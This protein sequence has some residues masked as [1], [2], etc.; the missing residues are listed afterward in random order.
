MFSRSHL[1]KMVKRNKPV[2]HC[3][4]VAVRRGARVLDLKHFNT[5]ARFTRFSSLILYHLQH[6][7]KKNLS[8]TDTIWLA[9][10]FVK[11]GVD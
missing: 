11:A 9:K 3:V 2:H 1:L 5:M 7:T 8:T 6:G 10:G 4:S